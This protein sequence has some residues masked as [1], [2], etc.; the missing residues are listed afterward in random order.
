M[1]RTVVWIK[2]IFLTIHRLVSGDVAT[3]NLQGPVGIVHLT[4]HATRY[5]LGTLLYFLALISVNLG[6]LNLLPFPIFDGGHL[7]LLACEKIK[8]SPVNE[9]IVHGATTVMFF[10]LIALAVYVTY[11]DVL[12]IL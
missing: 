2:R 6:V 10:L 12:R 8:G 7:L 11:H 3:R 9:R 5:G 4:G 1:K